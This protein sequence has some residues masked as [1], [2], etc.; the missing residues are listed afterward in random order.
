MRVVS[1]RTWRP[2]FAGFLA[3]VLAASC[4]G[5]G[6]SNPPAPETLRVVMRDGDTLPGGFSVNTIE[7][8][9]MA[10][11]QTIAV[12]ASEPGTPAQ[13]GVFVVS[14]SGGVTTIMSPSS[15]PEGLSLTTVRNLIMSPTGEVT[16]EVGDQL[17][18]D[19]VFYWDGELKTLARTE[20]GTTPEG[21]RILGEIRVADGGLVAFTDGTS[22]CEA[23]NSTGTL[24]IECTL[25][26]HTGV[27]GQL[28]QVSVPNELD[29]LAPTAVIVQVNRHQ[30]VAVGLPAGGSEP[31]VGTIQNGQF[32]GLLNRRQTFEGLGTLLAGRPRAIGSNSS[33]A[34]DAGFDTDGDGQRDRNRLLLYA[35]QTI[36][37]IAESG[38]PA[39][40]HDGRVVLDVRGLDIDDLG[41]V[42]YSIDVGDAGS[43]TS[44]LSLRV[45]DGTASQEIAFEGL[46]FGRDDQDEPLRV[47]EIEQIRVSRSGDVVFTATIGRFDEEGTRRIDRTAILRWSGGQE[48][49]EVIQ[50]KSTL[51]DG[52]RITSLS[53]QDV[54]ERGDLLVIGTID[55]QANRALLLLPR[56]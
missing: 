33:I 7:S 22:P 11:D 12:I 51:S 27:P 56:L 28:Q 47:L 38:V 52:G 9:N 42:V 10:A 44:F 34:I 40:G 13:N 23:N 19:G 25:R 41:R 24:R 31:L 18:S 26:I 1:S 21:F 53:I 30:E 32:Q 43:T 8:A 29:G 39:S 45:W 55:R 46:R 16:F 15:P 20:P 50:T 48:L 35:N 17:D 4:G 2:A 54:N 5:G 6:D 3:A 49:E 14:P 37:S 36:T